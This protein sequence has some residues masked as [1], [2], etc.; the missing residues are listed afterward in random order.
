ME[1]VII[2]SKKKGISRLLEL[3]SQKSFM[4]IISSIFSALS[5]ILQFV[6]YFASYLIA[7]EFILKNADSIDKEYVLYC[8]LGAILSVV[9]SMIFTAFSFTL[10]HFA[11]Y[12][13]LYNI[14]LKLLA[15][16]ATLP[17]GYFTASTKGEIHK[18]VQENV[19]KIE[20]FIAHKIPE[21]LMTLVG[22]VAIF[23][24][25][26]WANIW[27]GIICI[28]VYILAL[29]IQFSIYSKGNMKA[30]IKRF[31]DMQERI[32]ARS[33]EYVDGMSVVKLFNKSAFSF[34]N[35]ANSINAYKNYTLSYTYKCMPTFAGFNVL[36]NCF[37]FFI[38]PLGA[39]F[40]LREPQ[41]LVFVLTI[42]FFVMMSNGLISPLLKI[43]NLSSEIMQINEGVERIDKI[44]KVSALIESNSPKTP[45]N[46]DITF[47][48][49]SFSY[50]S[51]LALNNI[52]FSI[53]QGEHL[54][55]LG[56][57]G[58]GK[59]TI[60][61]LIA[62]FF[63]ISNGEILIGNVNIKDIK[64]TDLMDYL[65]LVTQDS[66]LFLDTLRENIKA[67]CINASEDRILKAIKDSN[68][69]DLADKIGLDSIINKDALSGGEAQRVNIARA[70]LK[71]APIFLL[72]EITANLD[73]YNESSIN[74][75]ISNLKTQNK[76]IIMV[77]HKLASVK[78]ADKIA[79]MDKGNLI[80]F[81]SH[82][83]L[84]KRCSMYQQMW[85]MQK[86]ATAWSVE[87]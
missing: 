3:S 37:I 5:A 22:A 30:E 66:F 49:V 41:D 28:L 65:S 72:D 51:N 1:N 2:D 50:D 87:T 54:V 40:V 74:V 56:E 67:G 55:I 31:Y 7:C 34:S 77:T 15:H 13:I 70:M 42:L 36:V 73:T 10:S 69:E 78:Y 26:L 57:S 85:E 63:D 43:L 8:G 60:L 59:S 75:A 53:K 33:I 9:I 46:F 58:S 20:N 76:T 84:K 21:F 64:N 52:N 24:V 83:E 71:N 17:L 18:N 4:L 68:C 62:R 61:S 81:G 14:R 23:G 38:M 16:L 44:F 79:I 27:L 25:F 29:Y 11:A 39:Y 82:N 12:R 86:F 48:N 47:K 19:E 80:D 32:N 35:L 6:P 45:N